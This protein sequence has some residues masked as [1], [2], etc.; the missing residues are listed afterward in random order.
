MAVARMRARWLIALALAGAAGAAAWWYD[1]P[2]PPPPYRLGA[3][4]RGPIVAS[5]AARITHK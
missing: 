1:R 4:D 3:I 5:V 2:A